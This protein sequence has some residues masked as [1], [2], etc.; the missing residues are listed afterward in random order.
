MSKKRY[1]YEFSNNNSRIG[2]SKRDRILT[3]DMSAGEVVFF[4][5]LPASL[6]EFIGKEFNLLATVVFV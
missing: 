3:A 6:L 4:W 5:Y 2:R 1:L